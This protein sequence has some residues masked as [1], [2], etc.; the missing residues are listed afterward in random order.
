MFI[1]LEE[2]R[3][4]INK[5][6]KEVIVSENKPDVINNVECWFKI[7]KDFDGNIDPVFQNNSPKAIQWAIKNDLVP[8]SWIVGSYCP[9]VLNGQ[10]G[11][12][13]FNDSKYGLKIVGINHNS[14]IEGDKTITLAICGP[15]GENIA[16][17]DSFYKIEGVE[18][19]FMMGSES[20]LGWE[21]SNLRNNICAQFYNC[22][23]KEWK[24]IVKPVKKYSDNGSKTTVSETTD[25]IFIPSET[26]IFGATVHGVEDEKTYCKLYP[27]YAMNGRYRSKYDLALGASSG[28]ELYY[29]TRT[30]DKTRNNIYCLGF[31]QLDQSLGGGP[32][33]YGFAPHFNIG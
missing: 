6:S 15:N 29:L 17:K 25:K 21:K 10:C 22:L 1:D 19:S 13:N 7:D 28:N 26:E 18:N 8:S 31:S 20:Q 9:V 12:L 27:Y 24:F 3:H 33:S 32:Y 16:F 4:K 30:L 14:E 5:K 2:N 11:Q 23:P